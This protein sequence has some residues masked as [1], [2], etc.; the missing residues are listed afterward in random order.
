[1][2]GYFF[3][4]PKSAYFN[5]GKIAAD[6]LKD[7]AVRKNMTTEEAGRWLAPNL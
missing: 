4:H 6:Q 7:Y 2:S 3:S 5:I 1:V